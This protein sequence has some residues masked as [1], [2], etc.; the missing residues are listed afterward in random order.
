MDETNQQGAQQGQNQAPT[1]AA[2]PPEITQ[3]VELL[4]QQLADMAARSQEQTAF[5]AAALAARQGGTQ[6]TAAPAIEVDP[7]ERKKIAAV[8][9]PELQALTAELKAM[10]QEMSGLG[11][12]LFRETQLKTVPP[13]VQ[14]A[15]E[16]TA[17]DPHFTGWSPEHRMKWAWGEAS[18]S[19][20]AKTGQVQFNAGGSGALGQN[21]TTAP[22]LSNATDPRNPGPLP[23]NFDQLKPSQRLAILEKRGLH[24]S[25]PI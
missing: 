10:R 15:F 19:M 25:L 18:M 11:S 14:K 5:I 22:P 7:E 24:K 3:Q 6:E 9:S 8:V 12:N 17:R 21:G 1:Q 4:K 13:E 2:V 16:A 23:D 20:H